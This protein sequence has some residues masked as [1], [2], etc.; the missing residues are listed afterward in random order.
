MVLK[1]IQYENQ[2]YKYTMKCIYLKSQFFNLYDFKD[3]KMNIPL[4]DTDPVCI[5]R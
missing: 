2:K 1:L 3:I 5:W 4:N